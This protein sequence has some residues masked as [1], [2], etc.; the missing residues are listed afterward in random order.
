MEK[1]PLLQQCF[2]YQQIKTLEN[3][4][5]Q[6][7][8]WHF[9]QGLLVIFIVTGYNLIPDRLRIDRLV[10]LTHN[11]NSIL[12]MYDSHNVLYI[13]CTSCGRRSV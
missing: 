5:L 6:K 1:T 7:K 12:T 10:V 8:L 2:H 13:Y 4:H 9:S 3:T 11:L